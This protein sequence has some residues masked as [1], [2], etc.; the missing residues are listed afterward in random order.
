MKIARFYVIHKWLVLISVSM[1]SGCPHLYIGS[2][3]PSALI[4][5]RL[6]QQPPL[7]NMFGKSLRRTRVKTVFPDFIGVFPEALICWLVMANYATVTKLG[8]N[9]LPNTVK[10]MIELFLWRVPLFVMWKK[11]KNKTKLSTFFFFPKTQSFPKLWL[12]SVPFHP[13]FFKK[14]LLR[15]FGGLCEKKL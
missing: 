4:I 9:V 5:R 8:Q 2:I 13:N 3:W 12:N 14:V 1:E 10:V 7:E 11:E 15:P 6:L